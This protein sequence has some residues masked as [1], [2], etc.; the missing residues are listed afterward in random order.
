MRP[1]FY[2]MDIDE[3]P[4]VTQELNVTSVPAFLMFRG[5]EVYGIVLGGYADALMR[6]IDESMECKLPYPGLTW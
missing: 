5:G 2:Q 4:E 3:M 1:N 6:A